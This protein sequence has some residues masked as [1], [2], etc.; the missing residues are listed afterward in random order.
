M[1]KHKPTTKITHKEI[2]KAVAKISAYLRVGDREK[3][4]EWA[5]QL[6]H[7][8]TV[9]G[10]YETPPQG[11]KEKEEKKACFPPTKG[12]HLARN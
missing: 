8:L 6:L 12:A 3:A 10:L 1:V 4:K 7:Y 2:C 5:A 9:L 11:E